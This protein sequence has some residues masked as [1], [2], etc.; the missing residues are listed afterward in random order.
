M[1]SRLILAKY[2]I[3]VS[4]QI[5]RWTEYAHKY[6]TAWN[7]WA[8]IYSNDFIIQEHNQEHNHRNAE[9]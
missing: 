8:I 6:R 2:A 4:L 5:T 3:F 7:N 1:N 9:L